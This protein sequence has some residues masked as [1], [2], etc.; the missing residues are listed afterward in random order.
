MT[1][2]RELLGINLKDTTMTTQDK[3]HIEERLQKIESHLLSI[4]RTYRKNR[5]T[6]RGVLY[7]TG[8]LAFCV[9][10]SWIIWMLTRG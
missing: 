8:T 4:D 9:L 3:V 5:R 10:A 2:I 7:A 6:I 1:F